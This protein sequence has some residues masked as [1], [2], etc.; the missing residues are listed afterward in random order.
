MI[1]E[2]RVTIKGTPIYCN[3]K[4]IGRV[5]NGTF[6]KSIATKHMLRTPKALCFDRSTLKDAA[7]AGATS[8]RVWNFETST[9]YTVSM[10]R[11]HSEGFSVQRGY[12]NQWALALEKWSVNGQKPTA[13]LKAAAT[14]REIADLQ[15]GLF[16][17][18]A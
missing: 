9:A 16:G 11:I 18:V 1:H 2:T 12:G 15:G 17:G 4:V 13:D 8:V 14:N 10:Q 5:D 7:A 6:H 3:G